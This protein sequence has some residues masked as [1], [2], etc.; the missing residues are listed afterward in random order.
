MLLGQRVDCPNHQAPKEVPRLSR[1]TSQNQRLLL[2]DLPGQNWPVNKRFPVP[3]RQEDLQLPDLLEGLHAQLQKLHHLLIAHRGQ[4]LCPPQRLGGPSQADPEQVPQPSMPWQATSPADPGRAARVLEVPVGPVLQVSLGDL[5][6]L[7]PKHRDLRQRAL[8]LRDR[9]R[10]RQT[11]ISEMQHSHVPSFQENYIE[12]E[13]PPLL[14]FTV[15]MYLEY[16]RFLPTLIRLH[17][18]LFLLYRAENIF[19]SYFTTLRISSFL[20]LLRLEYLLFLLDYT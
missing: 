17:Y 6:H 2:P 18:L 20:S 1:A 12:I 9:G 14:V 4:K 5:L 3:Q 11:S 19:S 8:R 15:H 13:C 7:L 16:L 10:Q